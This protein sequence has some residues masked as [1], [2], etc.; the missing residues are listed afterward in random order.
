MPQYEAGQAGFRPGMYMASTDE[1]YITVKGTGGHGA[2]PHLLADPVLIASHLIV[3][4]Q[5]IVSRNSAPE[6]PSVLSFGKFIANGATNVIPNEVQ[7]EGTFRTMHET[8]RAEAHQR[9]TLLAKSL[10][11]SMGADCDIEIR[12]G[13]P[14]LVNDPETTA[15]ARQS[16][17]EYLGSASIIDMDLRMTGE[18]F[19]YFTQA[20]PATFYR[21]GVKRPGQAPFGGLHTPD[22]DIDEDALRHGMGLMAYIAWKAMQ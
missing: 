16:A 12:N 19:A 22:F 3:A 5:Q 18:D 17:A 7:I 9:M 14:F 6:I 1:I 10:C 4:L 2:L 13:Y 11:Q 15:N 8:W 21:L 20:Y